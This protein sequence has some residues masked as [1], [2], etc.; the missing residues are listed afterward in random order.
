M[1]TRLR[2][3]FIAFVF[4][5]GAILFRGLQ[6]KLF[7]SENLQAAR[8]RQYQRVVRLKSKRGDIL[9]RHGEQLAISV[10]A[11]SLFADPGIIKN[12][13]RVALKLSRLTHISYRRLLK[14]ITRKNTRFVWIQRLQSKDTRDKVLSWNIRGL[15][16]KEEFK[17]I[18]PNKNLLSHVIGFVG[19]DE[20]GLEGLEARYERF[21][22]AETEVMHLP[23]DARGRFL[24]D[25]GW[26]FMHHRDGDDLYLTIDG[27]LQ[28]YVEQELKRAIKYHKADGAWAVVLDPKTSEILAISSQPDYDINYP[29]RVK[30]KRRRNRV[31][32]DVYEPGSTMKTVF[33]AG[34]LKEGIIEPNTLINTEGGEIK[35][36]GHT[37][38]ESDKEHIFKKLTVTEVL[39]YSSNV[40]IAKISLEMESDTIFDTIKEFGFGEKTG[41]DLV[42]ESGGLINSP[43]W[44][45]HLKANI[46]FGHGIAVTALQVA[47]AY[48]A[49]ANGGILHRPYIVKQKRGMDGL[50]QV[51]EP[52]EIRRVLT[53]KEAEKL[54]MMLVAA[55][56]KN[57]TGEKARVKGFP[58]A[59]KTGTAQKVKLNGRGYERGQYISSFVGFLPAN[60]PQFLIYVVIDNPQKHGYYASST[61]APVFS[62]IAQFA[63][64]RRGVAPVLISEA[65]LIQAPEKEI[66]KPR[67]PAEILEEFN[68]VPNMAGWT[69]R[70][71]MQYASRRN[72][73]L[74]VVG[75]HGRVVKTR[76]QEGVEWE[77]SKGLTVY[78]R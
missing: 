69:L 9:D 25:D 50:S 26:L 77:D 33:L 58:V 68:K 4:L 21:L 44:R 54:K 59:G 53:P 24:V 40:G 70:Q 62:R 5:W 36:D 42:G 43:P 76:P 15:G 30:A 52:E 56:G 57:G 74:K 37:I 66:E 71:V 12:P 11:Y 2:I 67:S 41:V 55:T 34:A 38:N 8:A 13:K 60:D 1:K 64:N 20:R 63:I 22:R 31:L 51:N 73:K 35:I 19:S 48:A 27:E 75:Q 61:A 29:R 17:R 18:Y 32:T 65:D 6:L 3:I 46:S 49:I 23:R 45:D 10:P 28:Y 16:Y 39:A 7:P 47:N 14:K 78:V 72:V